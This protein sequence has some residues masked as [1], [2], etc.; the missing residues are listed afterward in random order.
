MNEVCYILIISIFKF[1]IFVYFTNQIALKPSLAQTLKLVFKF[2]TIKGQINAPFWTHMGHKGRTMDRKTF[3][4]YY[5]IALKFE[6]NLIPILFDHIS[7]V[8]AQ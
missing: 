7:Q 1:L 6:M 5:T 8:I 4:R 3:I 2:S